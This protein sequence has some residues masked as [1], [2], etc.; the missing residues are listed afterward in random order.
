MTLFIKKREKSNIILN[1]EKINLIYEALRLGKNVTDARFYA[2]V[3]SKHVKTVLKEAKRIEKEI[4]S[5]MAK[6]ATTKTSLIEN[7]KSDILDVKVV[8]DDVIAWSNGDPDNAPTWIEYK[9][10]FKQEEI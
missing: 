5:M 7:I 4:T 10:F 6:G 9:K 8:L 2:N 3:P 1:K